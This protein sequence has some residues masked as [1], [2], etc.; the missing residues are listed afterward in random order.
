MKLREDHALIV[1]V[2]GVFGIA[3]ILNYSALSALAREAGIGSNILAGLFPILVDSFIAIAVWVTLRNERLGETAR[4]AWT[5]VI[6]F[7]A[8]SIALNLMHFGAVVATP[9]QKAIALSITVPSVVFIAAELIKNMVASLR[10]RGEAQASLGELHAQIDD[11]KAEASTAAAAT[12]ATRAQLA[13]ERAQLAEVQAQIAA[14]AA[15]LALPQAQVTQA[16]QIQALVYAGFSQKRAGEAVG[17]S[18]NTSR[19]R[20]E[21]AAELLNGTGLY[22][23]EAA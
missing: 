1:A 11:L 16:I 13:T 2:S 14:A 18:E 23:T 15:E 8:G 10:R 19:K 6:A 21:L 9:Q 5:T 7:T 22:R 3:A 4:L 12:E 20:L 17:V